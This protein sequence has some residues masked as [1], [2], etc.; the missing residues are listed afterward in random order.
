MSFWPPKKPKHPCHAKQWDA[1]CFTL[2]PSRHPLQISFQLA[3]HRA[4]Q[5]MCWQLWNWG[6]RWQTPPFA[7]TSI[8]ERLLSLVEKAP[9]SPPTLRRERKA[10][11]DPL[12]SMTC[13]SDVFLF[14]PLQFSAIWRHGGTSSPKY[15]W[16]SVGYRVCSFSLSC[17]VKS[18]LV[19]KSKLMDKHHSV[20][21]YIN[22]TESNTMLD[23]CY[24][25]VT[26]WS[27]FQE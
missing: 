12:G 9:L 5:Q 25:T 14:P 15:W 18:H 23:K 8:Y 27:K 22:K 26:K 21:H 20:T 17:R 6:M 7:G 19:T 2:T 10:T 11:A 13:S 4:D 24:S 16:I 1:V 3:R